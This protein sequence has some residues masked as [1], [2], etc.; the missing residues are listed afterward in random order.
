MIDLT[1]FLQALIGLL[2]ALITGML[3]PWI[4][5]K[6]TAQQ[7]ATMAMVADVLVYA[8]EQIYGAADGE[9]KLEYVRREM[10]KRGFTVDTAAIEAAVRRMNEVP[11][12]STYQVDAGTIC[13]G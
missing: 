9:A 13:E 4:K 1:P 6:T 12:T 5:S 10:E 2:A 3:V 8:A 11:A 7:Q